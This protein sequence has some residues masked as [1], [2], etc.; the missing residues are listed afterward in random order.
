M[1]R[2]R[3]NDILQEIR[4]AD[5]HEV[6]A[7]SGVGAHF[8][9][10]LRFNWN[11]K[12]REGMLASDEV[13]QFMESLSEEEV[14]C[15]DYLFVT[16]KSTDGTTKAGFSYHGDVQAH[17]KELHLRIDGGKETTILRSDLCAGHSVPGTALRVLSMDDTSLT[18]MP[19]DLSAV[20]EMS[21][22]REYFT[23]IFPGVEAM[24]TYDHNEFLALWEWL[25]VDEEEEGEDTP[26]YKR[27]HETKEDLHEGMIYLDRRDIDKGL[28]VVTIK[29]LHDRSITLNLSGN[30]MK[31]REVQLNCPN[32]TETIWQKGKRSLKARI[33]VPEP[34]KRLSRYYYSDEQVPAGCRVALTVSHE[35][36]QFVASIDIRD[37]NVRLK[38]ADY[39]GNVYW[40]W[41]S[42]WGFTD[43][44]MVVG[45]GNPTDHGSTFIGLLP[46][47]EKLV[48]PINDKTDYDDSDICLGQMEMTWENRAMDYE[49]EDGTLKSVP[50]MEEIVIPENVSEINYDA[51]VTAPSL[52]RLTIHGGV[53]RF[54]GAL[55]EFRDVRG[56]KLDITFTGTLQQWLDRAHDLGAYI[57]KL[58]I[59]GKEQDF[60]SQ[61][62]LVIPDGIVSIGDNCFE[63][64]D[65]LVSVTLPPSVISI[66]EHAFAYCRNLKSIK[67]LGPADIGESA[68]T[69]CSSLQELYL[70]DG[71]HSLGYGCLDYVTKLKTLFI[72]ASV[73]KVLI[74]SSQND[75]QCLAPTFL[76]EAPA[77]PE[78]W[79]ERWNLSYF[80]PRF[81]L[82]HGHD[83][84]HI[85]MWGC[86][87]DD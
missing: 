38:P 31:T 5:W 10:S 21:E 36:K 45:I 17:W 14:F 9:Y 42:A 72:P 62:H 79:V 49:I 40:N 64:C 37:I 83:H 65:N 81:G 16:A 44:K 75:G 35:G 29:K 52:S 63:H 86:K 70:A 13:V 32:L 39:Q 47:G 4:R 7:M 33:Y 76:C 20:A 46:P 51:L 48:F 84:Y 71:V 41:P 80:D 1:N 58:I 82:G 66:G 50:D 23:E 22:N 2:Q 27:H 8:T 74:I 77:R 59:E 57:G 68:F 26:W 11:M 85:A 43:G 19:E 56:H 12:W 61:E 34:R 30:G 28:P 18:L 25:Y 69:S 73:E 54:W 87:R 53:T 6:L 3:F 78:G 67:V 24:I 60:Y 15:L 55:Q